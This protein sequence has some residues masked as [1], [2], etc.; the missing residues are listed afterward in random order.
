MSDRYPLY[1]CPRYGPFIFIDMSDS[2]MILSI[3]LNTS[4]ILRRMIGEFS[5]D[6]H[7]PASSRHGGKSRWGNPLRRLSE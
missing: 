7:R 6:I 4:S 1:S 5:R 2:L 3:R